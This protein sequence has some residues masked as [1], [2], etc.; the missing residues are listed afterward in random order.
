LKNSPGSLTIFM[1]FSLAG[2]ATSIYSGIE[3]EEWKE[4]RIRKKIKVERIGK[5][6]FW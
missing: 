2:V 3:I 5:R 1:S 6:S 4:R